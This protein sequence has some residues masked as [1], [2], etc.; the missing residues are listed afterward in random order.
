MTPPSVLLD[1]TILAAVLDPEHPE[2]SIAAEVFLEL[3]DGFQRHH[4]R[5]RARRDHLAPIER[6]VRR[7]LLS[8][9]QAIHVAPQ[10]RRAAE[11][12]TAPVELSA[13]QR[14]TLVVMRRE[15]IDRIAT[16]D[17]AFAAFD[18]RLHPELTQFAE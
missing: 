14:I 5:L 6:R 11:R 18:V 8:P 17:P 3:V 13:D 4:I 12:L 10:H 9:V 7:S 15:R 1:A 16:L 2:A